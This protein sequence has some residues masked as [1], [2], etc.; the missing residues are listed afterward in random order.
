MAK[1]FNAGDHDP[2]IPLSDV[3]GNGVIVEPLHIGAT[4]LKVGVTVNS[5]LKTTFTVS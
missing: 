5:G 1:L 2:I 3:V 4:S